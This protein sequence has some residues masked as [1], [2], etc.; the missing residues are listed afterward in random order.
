LIFEKEGRVSEMKKVVLPQIC[1]FIVVLCTLPFVSGCKDYEKERREERSGKVVQQNLDLRSDDFPYKAGDVVLLKPDKVP[2]VIVKVWESCGE[3]PVGLYEVKY[4]PKGEKFTVV[5]FLNVTR[6]KCEVRYP[7]TKIH[8]KTHIFDQDEPTVNLH[9][10]NR[11]I[12][13]Y[14]IFEKIDDV[15]SISQI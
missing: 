8:T 1:L 4:D 12:N 11:A 14:E 9:Y 15:N 13:W 7:I 2:A 10:E 6:F 5:N 3:S